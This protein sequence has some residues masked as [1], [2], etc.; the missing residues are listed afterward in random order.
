M[1]YLQNQRERQYPNALE[2][3]SDHRGKLPHVDQA[4]KIPMGTVQA[5][6]LMLA[7]AVTEARPGV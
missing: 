1:L 3:F 5:T 7:R 2:K 6:E 4:G